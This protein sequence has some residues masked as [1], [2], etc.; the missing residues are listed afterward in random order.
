MEEFSCCKNS[1]QTIINKLHRKIFKNSPAVQTYIK[2]LSSLLTYLKMFKIENVEIDLSTVAH[3]RFDDGLMFQI[4]EKSS[5]D[6]I[7]AGGRYDGLVRKLGPPS[8]AAATRS[9]SVVGV[10]IPIE[11]LVSMKLAAYKAYG[12]EV[13]KC[14]PV[15]MEVFIY[16]TGRNAT[17][18][19]HRIA[20]AMELWESGIRA[21]YAQVSR[22]SLESVYQKCKSDGVKWIV[23]LKRRE[24]ETHQLVK[25]QEV[26]TREETEMRRDTLVDYLKRKLRTSAGASESIVPVN[27]WEQYEH[28]KKQHARGSG[29]SGFSP[30]HTSLEVKILNKTKTETG[31][32]KRSQTTVKQ[33]NKC[34][35]TAVIRSVNVN[36]AQIVAVD[37]PRD[38]VKEIAGCIASEG[39]LRLAS[40]SV[41]RRYNQTIS[42]LRDYLRTYTLPLLFVYSIEHH[43]YELILCANKQ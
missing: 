26:K 8:S 22:M 10:T 30:Q 37:L 14:K 25:V 20:V 12:S 29:G 21:N 1:N 35:G 24:F 28:K 34:L 36:S 18:T 23:I 13:V 7:A 11:Q 6:S 38:V 33:A 16:S 4:V 3:N 32:S 19:E 31:A 42:D 15:E 40:L 2:E 43:C 41:R 17:M 9:V 39:T 27:R 5:G